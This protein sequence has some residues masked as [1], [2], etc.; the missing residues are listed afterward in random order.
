MKGNKLML[1]TYSISQV[2]E[3]LQIPSSTM[4][5]YD[6]LNL[7]PQLQ[8]NANGVRQFAQ[9]DIDSLR[10]IECLKRSG[11]S[12]KEIKQFIEL[13]QQGD[14]SIEAR[15]ELFYDARENFAKKLAQMQETMKVLDFK[16]QYY[17]QALADGTETSV[18]KDMSLSDV[19]S[20]ED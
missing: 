15:R 20:V 7:L 17:D 5:Y 8:K 1:K 19:V 13:S 16:C 4:R 2:S 14:A 3:I 12:M 10:V 6:S 9:S 18:Q 11:L